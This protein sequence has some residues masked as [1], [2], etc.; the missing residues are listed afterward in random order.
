MK[1]AD[2]AMMRQAMPTMPREGSFHSSIGW[3]GIAT[4][5]LI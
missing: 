3:W 4:A 5:V 2:S 1:M